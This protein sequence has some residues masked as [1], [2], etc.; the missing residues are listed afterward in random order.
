MSSITEAITLL[1][2]GRPILV[3]DAPGREGETDL[4]VASQFITPE[5]I[6][7]MRTDAGGLVCATVPPAAWKRMGLPYMDDV[8]AH[9]TAAY[10]SLRGLVRDTLPYDQRSAFSLSV[11]HAE[12]YT[13][14]TDADRS[15][16]IR[17]LAGFVHNTLT[18][19][20]GWDPTAFGDAFR[21]PGHVPLLN[22]APGLLDERRGHT[23]L[24]TV[25]L[26]MA[27]LTPTATLCEMLGPDGKALGVEEAK[28]YA[29]HHHTVFLRGE[30]IVEAW[31]SWSG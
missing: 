12:T 23:E 20:N 14:I 21:A 29:R 3:Y 17:K 13:G 31:G 9:A 2:D 6:R 5:A 19:S 22:A 30:E 16:T 10:P 27:D 15:L 18:S 4:V 8:L 11:N 26:M 7:A 25:L 28:A 1:K 24:V